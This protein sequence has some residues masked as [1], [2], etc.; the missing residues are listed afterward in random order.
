MISF[1]HFFSS[2]LFPILTFA[3]ILSLTRP[4]L[5]CTFLPFNIFFSLLFFSCPSR[6]FR[7]PYLTSL[8]AHLFLVF[9]T[10]PFTHPFHIHLI[11]SLLLF[12][13]LHI[14]HSSP[15]PH[16]LPSLFRCTYTITKPSHLSTPF[17]PINLPSV[18]HYTHGNPKQVYR[19]VSLPGSEASIT[20]Q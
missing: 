14:H 19:C 13:L 17:E 4:S 20:C 18:L 15:S 7:F 1:F 9:L 11:F 16:T 6:P 12:P 5:P 2:L 8:P 3:A 10:F